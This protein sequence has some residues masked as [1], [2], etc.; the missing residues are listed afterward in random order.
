MK[1]GTF[2]SSRLKKAFA[3]A[4]QAV[5]DPVIP[6]PDDPVRQL[7][8]AVLGVKYG[9]A[10]ATRAIDRLLTKMADWNE[11]RVSRP[12]EINE[13]MGNANPSRL[14]QCQRLTKALQSVF[15]HEN[16]ISLNRLKQLGRREARQYLER[17][18]G[19]DEY[20]VASIALWSLGGHGI[21]VDDQFL[22]ALRKA[23][24]VHPAA[25][26]SEVQAFLER[27]VSATD[28][29]KFCI[30]MRSFMCPGAGRGK[31]TK[32]NTAHKKGKTRA[33]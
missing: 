25:T 20:V 12:S 28:A 6:E 5:R 15:D 27:H 4:R 7:G 22:E 23:E 33:T 17:L 2:Y 19:V 9:D 18:E 8:I 21:P 1:Q 10:Q 31:R 24:L 3:K 32:S 13:A 26:R 30:V 29:K 14:E 16:R 11:V